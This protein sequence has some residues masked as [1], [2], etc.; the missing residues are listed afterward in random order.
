M[1]RQPSARVNPLHPAP[2][3]THL[4]STASAQPNAAMTALSG[5]GSLWH[6]GT[7][8]QPTCLSSTH[9]RRQASGLAAT[10][11]APAEHRSKDT[12]WCRCLPCRVYSSTRRRGPRELIAAASSRS[13]LPA[14]QTQRSPAAKAAIFTG[15][16]A[17][18]AGIA[19]VL[20]PQTVFGEGGAAKARYSA[21]AYRSDPRTPFSIQHTTMLIPAMTSAGLLFNAQELTVGWIRV[22]GV[23]FALI[24]MQARMHKLK[25]KQGFIILSCC[26]TLRSSSNATLWMCTLLNATA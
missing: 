23:L 16:Y 2:A 22:G 19:L 15:T 7:A 24:G 25:S 4:T 6:Q 5:L 18:I 26:S 13:P 12:R 14:Q 3:L 21:W 17:T 1:A 20:A 11:D 9:V 10:C 8:C